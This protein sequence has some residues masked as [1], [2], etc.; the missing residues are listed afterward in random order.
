MARKFDC[1]S[2]MEIGYNS[3]P[4]DSRFED[5]IIQREHMGSLDTETETTVSILS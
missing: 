2:A 3:P 5:K 4:A 1:D